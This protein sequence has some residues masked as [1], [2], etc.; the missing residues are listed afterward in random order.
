[1]ESRCSR[2]SRRSLY[3]ARSPCAAPEMLAG[4]C[5][6]VRL[7]AGRGHQRWPCE[8]GA[9]CARGGAQPA[10]AGCRHQ[11][12]VPSCWSGLRAVQATVRSVTPRLSCRDR[13]KMQWGTHQ[14]R[15]RAARGSGGAGPPAPRWRRRLVLRDCPN[16]RRVSHQLQC[17]EGLSK[18]QRRFRPHMHT[19]LLPLPRAR[20][21]P[22]PPVPAAPRPPPEQRHPAVT[23]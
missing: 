7:A 4:L 5:V 18:T 16:F 19:L 8:P 6:Q 15:A 17:R 9:M 11:M 3:P 1:M 22:P 13:F 23:V 10:R 20:A 2:V 14:H 21:L 12:A